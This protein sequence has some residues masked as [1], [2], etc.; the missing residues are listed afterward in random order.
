[1]NLSLSFNLRPLDVRLMDGKSLGC[2]TS[3]CK[4]IKKVEQQLDVG[5]LGARPLVVKP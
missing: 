4:T 3:G 2:K 1:M 5:K